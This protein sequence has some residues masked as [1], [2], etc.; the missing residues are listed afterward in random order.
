[1]YLDMLNILSVLQRSGGSGKDKKKTG[2]RK[3]KFKTEEC[4]DKR[5]K[6]RINIS[7]H[8]FLQEKNPKNSKSYIQGLL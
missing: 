3:K 6:E 8:I 1:M 7:Y 4:H 2:R 5:E